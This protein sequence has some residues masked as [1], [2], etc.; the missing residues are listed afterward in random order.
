MSYVRWGWEN[1]DVYIFGGTY[2]EGENFIECCGCPLNGDF[3]FIRF[4]NYGDL[5]RHIDDHRGAGDHVPRFVDERIREEISN[6]DG[7]WI[8]VGEVP[9][10]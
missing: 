10:S 9:P 3:E 1:S 2:G 8:A 7:H 4:T 5:L 6:P